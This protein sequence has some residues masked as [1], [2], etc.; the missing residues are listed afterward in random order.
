MS[1]DRKFY[2]DE[3]NVNLKGEKSESK[4]KK[5]NSRFQNARVGFSHADE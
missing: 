2:K 1:I 4:P 5:I 3:E